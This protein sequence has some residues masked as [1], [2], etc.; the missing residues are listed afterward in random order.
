MSFI[1]KAWFTVYTKKKKHDTWEER[2][3]KDSWEYANENSL[4]DEFQSSNKND[5]LKAFKR[6]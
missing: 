3:E 2:W 5:Q 4:S 6:A 1:V